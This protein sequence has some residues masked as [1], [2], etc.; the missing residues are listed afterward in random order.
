MSGSEDDC[1]TMMTIRETRVKDEYR[2]NSLKSMANEISLYN[3][4]NQSEDF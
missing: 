3:Y 4:F 2:A 1:Q